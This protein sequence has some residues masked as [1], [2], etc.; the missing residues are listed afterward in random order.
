[1]KRY[2]IIEHTADLGLEI[3]GNSPDELFA[4]AAFAVFDLMAD[5]APVRTDQERTITV[6]GADWEDLLVNYLRE[7]LYM[8]NGEGLLLTEFVI[9]EIGPR[10]LSGVVRG[11]PFDI[12]KHTVK[13]EIKAVTYHGVTV[14]ELREGWR[15]KVIFDV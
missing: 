14:E 9:R 8:F 12:R 2:R 15:G 4:N 10:H 5:L 11:E 7:I 6:D 3:F 1:M 13:K